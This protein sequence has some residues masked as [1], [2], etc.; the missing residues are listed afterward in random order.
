MKKRFLAMLFSGICAFFVF[1]PA[2]VF[3]QPYLDERNPASSET[4]VPVDTNITFRIK[5]NAADISLSSIQVTVQ[6]E[7]DDAATDIIKDGVSALVG[8]VIDS[9]DARNILVT[10]DPPDDDDHRFCFEQVITV[11]V[12]AENLQSGSLDTQYSFTTASILQ[13]PNV[14]VNQTTDG[15]QRNSYMVMDHSGKDVYVVW[16]DGDGQ[17]WFAGSEDRGETFSSE[18]KISPDNSGFNENPAMAVDEPGNIYVIWQS[19]KGQQ[20]SELYFCRKLKNSQDFE[21]QVIPVDAV[22]GQDSDQSFPAIRAKSSGSVFIAWVNSISNEGVFYSRSKDSG[23]S[24]GN[25]LPAEIHQVDDETAELFQYP[26]IGIDSSGNN[27][28][29]TWSAVKDNKRNIYFNAFSYDTVNKIDVKVYA[30][31]I[32]INDDSSGDSCDKPRISNRNS[33]S[34]G[35]KK[36]GIV[37]VWEN[38]QGQDTDIFLDS[39]VDGSSWGADAQVNT[40]E[41]ASPA[42]QLEAQVAM[43]ANGDIFCAWADKR[44]GHWDIYAAYSLDGA[45]TFKDPIKLNSDDSDRDQ[46]DPSLYLSANGKNFCVSW[47]DSGDTDADIYFGRN[48]VIDEEGGFKAT[49]DH[50]RDCSLVAGPATNVE[51]AGVNIPAR[52]LAAD[53][54]ISVARVYCP[55]GFIFGKANLNKFVHFGPS[56]TKFKKN[57]TIK[58]PYT[59]NELSQAGLASGSALAIYYFNPKTKAWEL[60]PGSIQDSL[61][62]LVSADV[63]HF[64]SFALA[65]ADPSSGSGGGGGGGGGGCFIATAAFGSYEAKEVKVLRLFRDQ[66]LLSS[67]WG[68]RLVRFYYSHSPALARY[69]QDKP[70]LKSAVRLALKPIV[71]L[72]SR[73]KLVR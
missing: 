7:G 39:S 45:K 52:A 5:D 72:V 15:D 44:G 42:L 20:D 3:A 48:T 17:I 71:S 66:Y 64:S 50:D 70:G 54:E 49:A 2:Y 19:K 32:R 29:I 10:Y 18:I 58:I 16:Q 9:T 6:R 1:S 13:A 33:F 59:L 43:D 63:D 57:V 36:P 73:L 25:I 4:Q 62:Q 14:R 21:A 34:G 30:S 27:A 40:D 65:E 53:T 11:A 41:L 69:I 12:K 67:A 68:K 56:G 23:A 37:I 31:D 22:L 24:F 55:P 60:V 38:T 26:D 35:G 51:N 47:N 8:A 28:I 61:R 46:S